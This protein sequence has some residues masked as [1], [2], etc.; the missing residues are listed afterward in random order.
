MLLLRL[1][2]P[3]AGGDA[4]PPLAITVSYRDRNMAPF[5]SRKAVLL[6]DWVR[7]GAGAVPVFQSTGV[8]KAVALAR[9]MDALQSW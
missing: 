5:S 9:Y 8:R 2:A 1:K 3:P 7:A 4:P 6:P